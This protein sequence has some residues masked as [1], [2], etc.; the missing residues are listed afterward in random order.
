MGRFVGTTTAAAAFLWRSLSLHPQQRAALAQLTHAVAD[1]RNHSGSSA[2]TRLITDPNMNRKTR[3]VDE[4]SNLIHT[5]RYD[6]SST[7]LSMDELRNKR[8]VA[9]GVGSI[10]AP[11][12]PPPKQP[13]EAKAAIE[14]VNLLDDD[15]SM[16][17]RPRTP[18]SAENPRARRI[19][20]LAVPAQTVAR[21]AINNWARLDDDSDDD[22]AGENLH[23][24]AR[25]LEERKKERSAVATLK[26]SLFSSDSDSNLDSNRRKRVQSGEKD[27]NADTLKKRTAP[28]SKP[29]AVQPNTAAAYSPA[30]AATARTPPSSWPFRVATWNV[31]FGPRGDGDPH[32]GPRMRAIVRLLTDSPAPRTLANPATAP[33]P[34]PLWCVGFQEVIHETSR[35]LQPA[36]ESLGYTYVRQPSPVAYGCALA[37]HNSLEILER[38]WQAYRGSVMQRGFLYA[39]VRLPDSDNQMIFTTTHLESWAGPQHTGASQRVVQLHEMQDFVNRQFVQHAPHLKAAVL[40]GDMNWDDERARSSRVA[41]IDPA[42]A[43][44]L[45]SEWK[46][47]WLETKTITSKQT[48]YTYD[49]K[50]NPMLGGNLRRRFDRC[51]LRAGNSASVRTVSTSLLGTEAIPDL[52]WQKYNDWNRSFKE[53]PTAPSDHFGYVANLQIDTTTGP[54]E[55]A[56]ER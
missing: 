1:C 27:N 24:L 47:S 23:L 25:Q 9:L 39:R 4:S 11:E 55:K 52:T 22:D 45:S 48:C 15:S 35:Y 19:E 5:N 54:L 37:V 30:A 33:P 18:V 14:V 16:E 34:H 49:G 32:A 12:P 26:L 51:L 42:M 44:I 29:A 21:R 20:T 36:L 31:W 17:E 13:N 28:R 50:M 38:D 53:M 2:W 43:T 3:N 10:V 41:T 40:T 8:L 46:D 7:L 56:N 6:G